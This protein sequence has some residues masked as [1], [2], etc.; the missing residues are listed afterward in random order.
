MLEVSDLI[1]KKLVVRLRRQHERLAALT[2]TNVDNVSILEQITDKDGNSRFVITDKQVRQG[3]KVGKSL[4]L[5]YYI[6]HKYLTP[7]GDTECVQTTF[8]CTD[9]KM[10]LCE[11]DRSNPTISREQS[12]GDEHINSKCKIVGCY[13]SDRQYSNFPKEQQVQ[14]GINRKLARLQR[15]RQTA[16]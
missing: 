4:H 5:N 15:I 14:L 13:G 1:C 3:R 7:M 6:C 16:V 9:C 2:G 12:C 11:N 8:R 10:P